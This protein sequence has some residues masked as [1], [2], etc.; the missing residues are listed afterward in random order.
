MILTETIEIVIYSKNIHHYESFGYE[1]LKMHQKLIVPVEYLLKGS[2]L[3]VEVEC[4]I[5]HKT[6]N[7]HQK[8]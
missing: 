8:K 2:H 3:K 1:N 7:V 4:D 5:C 6:V